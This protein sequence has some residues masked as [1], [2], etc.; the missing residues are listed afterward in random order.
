[1]IYVAYTIL[2]LFSAT[3]AKLLIEFFMNYRA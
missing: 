3:V 1:M 2:G